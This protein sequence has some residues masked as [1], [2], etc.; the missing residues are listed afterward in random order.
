MKNLFG[1]D[2]I[3]GHAGEFP[4]DVETVR[5]IGASLAHQLRTSLD[6]L[7]RIVSGRD[8]RESGES[9]ERAFHEGAEAA[10]AECVSAGII[11]TPGIAYLTRTRGFDAGVVISAS[12]NPFQ[13]NGI[14]IF[15]P[16]GK[17]ADEATERTIEADVNNGKKIEIRDLVSL[18]DS[19][20][21]QLQQAYSD[22]L[23]AEFPEL[24][25][26][27]LKIIVDCANGAASQLAPELFGRFGA[28]V[29]AIHAEPNGRNINENCGSLHLEHLQKA[30]IGSDADFGVAF[31]GDADR[32]LFVNEKGKIVDGD[33]TLWIMANFL[34]DHGMLENRKV[35]ATVMSNIGL[36]LALRSLG[37]ELVRTSVGDKYV[38]DELLSS[39]SEIGGEQS[40]HVIFPG[41]S[42]VGDG[43]L[44]SLFVLEAIYERSV[45]FSEMTKGFNAYP[46]I[47]VN[48]R[49][50]ERRPFADVPVIADAAAS[51]ERELDGK[52]R[53]LLRYSGTENL[54][55]VMIEGQDQAVIT[56]QANR[57][58]EVIR[59]SLN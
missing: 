54:A 8:T 35:I 15:T 34:L 51:I 37:V 45:P 43:I 21:I 56:E 47:L 30:V 38:L 31:D 20:S 50:K 52:G 48:V 6:R 9:I 7:P 12:H 11:T 18:D 16:S 29:T 4:L 1:T 40:G 26:S 13:D 14:K 17:K 27:K 2:G 42:I 36:E 22:H 33:A 3:R 46:Q 19:N 5:M 58:A 55:R 59:T 57:L 41:K 28:D 32:A 39:G 24:D 10:G 44:T 23:A 53:L 25:L 49:V